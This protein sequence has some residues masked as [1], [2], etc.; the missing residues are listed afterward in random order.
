MSI[1][2]FLCFTFEYFYYFLIFLFIVYFSFTWECLISQ[3]K[4]LIAQTF[5]LLGNIK[6]NHLLIIISFCFI[7]R[8]LLFRLNK[9]CY[10]STIEYICWYLKSFLR[11]LR[12]FSTYHTLNY[13]LFSFV[14]FLSIVSQIVCKHLLIFLIFLFVVYFHYVEYYF[15]IFYLIIFYFLTH[16]QSYCNFFIIIV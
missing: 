3:F 9:F 2:F 7:W 8:T 15:D 16:Y 11:S 4:Y 10:F 12:Y 5:R 13:T 1:K 14:R 6:K